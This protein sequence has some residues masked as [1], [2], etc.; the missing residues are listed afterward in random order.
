[1]KLNQIEKHGIVSVTVTGKTEAELTLE[2]KEVVNQIVEGDKNTKHPAIEL[3]GGFS[4]K[5][6]EVFW[7]G[8]VSI[9]LVVLE[10]RARF[11]STF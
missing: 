8:V 4:E 3:F 5:F 2:L 11:V 7:L 1:M 6:P 10:M 9:G